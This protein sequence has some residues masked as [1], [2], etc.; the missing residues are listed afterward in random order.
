LQRLYQFLEHS[1]GH[2]QRIAF[3]IYAIVRD[4]T[5]NN[6][7]IVLNPESSVSENGSRHKPKI[8]HAGADVTLVMAL[9][10]VN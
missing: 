7:D 2:E 5:R 4:V 9:G 6:K 3:F 10:N 8:Q 1:S